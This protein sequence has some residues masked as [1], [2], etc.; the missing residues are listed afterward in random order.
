MSHVACDERVFTGSAQAKERDNDYRAGLGIKRNTHRNKA[1]ANGAKKHDFQTTSSATVLNWVKDPTM[2]EK[3]E[4][5]HLK[6]MWCE[7][8]EHDQYNGAMHHV[9]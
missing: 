8:R 1:V 4:S 5:Q 3:K 6:L 7:L 9:K 2:D